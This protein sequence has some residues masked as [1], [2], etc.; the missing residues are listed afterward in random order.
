M[1]KKRRVLTG[2]TQNNDEIVPHL[3]GS[4]LAKG[5]AHAGY[6]GFVILL[7]SPLAAEINVRHTDRK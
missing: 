2:F 5:K 3:Q 4:L 7:W 1:F 6:V